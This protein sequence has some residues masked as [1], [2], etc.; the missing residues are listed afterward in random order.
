VAAP[1]HPSASRRWPY[2]LAALILVVAAAAA[3]TVAGNTSPNKIAGTAGLSDLGP[4]PALA[5]S[6]EWINSA[7]LTTADLRGKVVLYDFWTYS[8]VNCVRTL[9]YLR[10]W[11]T[12]Y[13]RDGLVIVGV[14]SPE[15]QFEHDLGNVR[16]AVT[17]LHVSYPVVLDNQLAIWGAFKNNYWPADYLADRAGRIRS[18]HIGEGDYANTETLLRRLLGVE[19][20]SPRAAA[21]QL[22]RAGSSPTEADRLTLE[23][24]LGT[25]RGATN[26]NPGTR[27]YTEP[28]GDLLDGEARVG[29]PWTATEQYLRSGAAGA[30]IVLEYRAREV[31][32]VM[33]TDDGKPVAVD[34][35]V[36]GKPL[37]P[38]YRTSQTVVDAQGHTSVRVAASDLYRL[39]LGPAIEVHTLRLVAR[40][41]GLRAFA[42]TFGS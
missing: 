26:A 5:G 31:N 27:T 16:R 32:L 29:G 8:C 30:S 13:R 41:P 4:V 7:P 38:S 21:P 18:M 42:F 17:E 34:V 22:P 11:A 37:A 24:Y 6:G 1:I 12:R 14:H 23:T 15:F 28:T 3:V 20:T 40:A 25:D 39:V 33:A 10:S 9:P 35:F 19:K 2:V 36:D